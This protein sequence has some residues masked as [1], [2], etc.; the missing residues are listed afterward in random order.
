M[1][2]IFKRIGAAV[3]TTAALLTQSL[4]GG[5]SAMA[6]EA[7]TGSNISDKGLSQTVEGG[8]ILHC[9]CW[10]FETI[11][12]KMPEIAAAGFSAVQTSPICEVNNGGDGSLT[13]SGGDNWWWHYQPTDYK[14]GN[15]QFGTKEQFREMCDTAHSYGIKVIVDSVLNHTTA[16]YDKISDNIKNLPGKAFHP[17]GEEREPGQNWSEVDRYEETQ[18]DLSGL[19]DLN[20]QNKEVQNYILNFLK[21]CVDNGADGFRYD[22]AKLIELPDDTSE[23]YGNE[24]ASDFWPTI[25]QNGAAFQY[26]EV[27][28]EGGKHTYKNSATGYDDNDSSRLGAY[29]SQAYTDKDGG[30]HYMNTSNSYTGFRVRDAIANKNLAADFVMDAMLPAGAKADQTVTWVESHDNYCNDQSYKELTETQQVIQAWAAIA[31][32]KDGTPLFFDRPNNS[33]AGNPWGDNKIGP[34]GSDMYKDPQVAAVNFFRNEMG[35]TPQTACNPIEGNDQVLMIERGDNNKGVVIINASSEDIALNAQTGMTDGSYTDQAFGGAF[36]VSDG[37][38]SGTVK[39]GKV[40]VVYHSNIAD[41][42]KEHFAPAVNLSVTSGYFLTDTLS[43]EATVRSCDYAEYTLTIND[44]T[45]TG[46]VSAGDSILIENVGNNQKATLTLTGYNNLGDIDGS[47]ITSIED[48][49]LLQ[50]FIAELVTLDDAQIQEADVDRNGNVNIADAT[51][52]QMFIAE[53]IDNNKLATVTREYTHWV[54]QDNTIVYLEPEAKPDW[55]QAYVYIWGSAENAGWPGVKMERTAQGLYRYILPYQYEL[56]GSYGNVIFNNSKGQQF[57]AGAINP[58]QQ[59]VYTADGKWKAYNES[60]YTNPSVGLSA[61]TGYLPVGSADVKAYVKN[62]ASASY[63]VEFNGDSDNAITGEAVYGC[64]IPL[65]DL[66]HNDT[67][68]VTLTGFDDNG[69][70]VAS[71]TATYTGWEQQGNTIIYMEQ[72][73]RPAWS[74]VNAYIWGSYENKSWPGVTMEKLNNDVYKLVLPYQYEL[75]NSVGNVIF[76][77]NGQQFDAG[78]I[79]PGEKMIYTAD[80]KWLAYEEP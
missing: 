54:K 61:K 34:E 25:L 29:H 2:K 26:G 7:N 6:A 39:A 66:Q 46:T 73:A 56:D 15:Y 23:K 11:K 57:D 43:V 67:A 21:D 10:D 1:K 3:L 33:S 64:V 52:I 17:M 48:V 37:V 27:L 41:E 51:V 44:T 38:L 45:T 58:G 79:H 31:A 16:Y 47:G 77:S 62:C 42:N 68:V 13:I 24:F 55:E 69:D 20:T 53:L 78:T 50:Q 30:T 59:M 75:P 28:Q 80:G 22:A 70:E 4:T 12:E 76:N 14:I 19:Y 74:S 40:A 18:Y 8:A 35:T 72:A 60:D 5:L 32:R 9:W 71:A 36:T 49:T 63:R 65:D